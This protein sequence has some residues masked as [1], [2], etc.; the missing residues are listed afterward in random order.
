MG[1]AM[2]KYI[3]FLIATAL[4]SLPGQASAQRQFELIPSIS[5]SETYDDNIDLTQSNEQSDF[6]TTATPAL[7]LNVLTQNTSLGMTYAPSFVWYNDFTENDTTRHRGTVSW[8]QQLTQRMSFNL[9]NTYLRSEDPLE[10]T[11]DVQGIRQT[12]NKYWVNTARASV[13]YVFG[14]ENRLDVGY[15]RADRNNDEITLD[16]SVIQT[17]FANMTYWFNVKNGFQLNYGYTDAKFTRDD[18]L[19]A[20]SDYTSNA[21]GI[22]Y[23]RRFTPRSTAYL[24]YTYTTFDYERILPQDYNIHDPYVGLEHAFS[25]ELSFSG[26]FG[27][28]VKVNEFTK[29]DDGPTF[30]L[31]LT[32]TFSRGDI[33][34]GGTGGWYQESLDPGLLEGGFREYYGGF[35]RG[36]YQLLE[37]LGIYA[38]ASYRYEKDRLDL[39]TS[40]FI[41]ANCGLRW[42]FLRWFS[43]SLEY[44][45]AKSIDDIE[46]DSYT[47]NRVMLVL[48]ASKPYKW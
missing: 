21:A 27:W 32:R 37:R 26:S 25:P 2:K 46:I 7:T 6:I 15:G 5:V 29:N 20:S 16:N 22:R 28:F 13:G 40:D 10:D 8:D 47:N 17:P 41:R 31:S 44:S 43:M 1:F 35:I 33:T 4:V 48:S 34:I 19:L 39:F 11:L 23:M 3:L 12:R 18:N 30:N 24:G 9:T 45:F 36:T 42:S 14:A 38:G